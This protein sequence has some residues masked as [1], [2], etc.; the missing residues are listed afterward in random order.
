M[1]RPP[2]ELIVYSDQAREYTT[3]RF[4]DVLARHGAQQGMSR[5]GNC[6]DDA[7][8]STAH[9]KSIWSRFKAELLDGG[10]YPGLPKRNLKPATTSPV[11]PNGVILYSI[12]SRS[13]SSKPNS[14]PRPNC[15]RLS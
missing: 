10:Y 13:T 6:Y 9:T 15:V 14:K 5:R 2:P 3:T 11:T 12:T 7:L 8:P 1:R 4:K